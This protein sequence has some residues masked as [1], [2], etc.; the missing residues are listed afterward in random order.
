MAKSRN[1]NLIYWQQG[2]VLIGQ[3][4]I[5]KEALQIDTNVLQEGE[6]TGHAHRLFEGDF[7]V[8]ETP[9]KE[10]YLRIVTPTML[11]HEEHKQIALNPG[12]Y[13]IG[14]VEEYDPFSKMTRQV[15]D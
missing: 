12:D 15:V 7:K 1:S 6:H 11:R 13:K 3:C 10:K 2:D 9:S 4:E 8:F 14:I 5:P